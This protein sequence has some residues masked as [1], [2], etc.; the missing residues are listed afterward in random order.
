M[1]QFTLDLLWH[2]NR[3]IIARGFALLGVFCAA[4]SF[5]ETITVRERTWHRA[6]GTRPWQEMRP[7][8]G[9]LVT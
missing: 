5:E 3:G 7:L 2:L 8:R 6:T 1:N 9:N 4:D